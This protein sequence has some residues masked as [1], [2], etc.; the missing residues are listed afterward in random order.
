M[1]LSEVLDRYHVIPLFHT[2]IVGFCVPDPPD[3]LIEISYEIDGEVYEH[4]FNDQDIQP[5]SGT[6]GSFTVIDGDGEACGYIALKG[7]ELVLP[8]LVGEEN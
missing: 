4:Y 6:A 1:K 2:A 3:E 7:V 8:P 5:R